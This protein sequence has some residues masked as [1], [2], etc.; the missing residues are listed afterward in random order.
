MAAQ[1]V[2]S[3]LTRPKVMKM[4]AKVI[5]TPMDKNFTLIQ[6]WI[7]LSSVSA[8]CTSRS[9]HV[10]CALP[11]YDSL[12]SRR[13]TLVQS[14]TSLAALAESSA[15]MPTLTLLHPQRDPGLCPDNRHR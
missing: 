14:T 15:F 4:E 7:K 9:S 11:F 2:Q 1:S 3:N 6:S 13:C 10:S 5:C 8:S 12:E